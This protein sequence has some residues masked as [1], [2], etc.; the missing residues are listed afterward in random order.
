[1]I[2]FILGT[3]VGVAAGFA[4]TGYL[5]KRSERER[6]LSAPTLRQEPP[7]APSPSRN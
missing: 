1:V 2:R 6:Q 3:I 7:M 4:V 5:E